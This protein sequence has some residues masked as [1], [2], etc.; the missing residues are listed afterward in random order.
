MHPLFN[1]CRRSCRARRKTGF[2]L[3]EIMIVVVIIGLLLAIAFP[4]FAKARTE[5]T[6]TAFIADLRVATGAFELYSLENGGYPP[7]RNPGEMPAGMEPYL[8]GIKWTEST[9]IG[10][11]WDWDYLTFGNK[12]GV[13][14]RY[15]DGGDHDALLQEI[16]KRIDDGDLSAGKLQKRTSGYIWIIEQR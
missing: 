15:T 4:Y 11:L 5:S 16:D 2:T 13:S 3:V 12:I 10:G 14:V 9:P 6:I 1:A 7:D 8:S